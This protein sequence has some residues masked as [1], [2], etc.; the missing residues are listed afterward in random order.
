MLMNLPKINPKIIPSVM[1]EVRFSVRFLE[2]STPVFAKAKSGK[3]INATIESNYARF[4]GGELSCF[5]M[6]FSVQSPLHIHKNSLN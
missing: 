5:K 6:E 1:L 2:N 3:I 4:V